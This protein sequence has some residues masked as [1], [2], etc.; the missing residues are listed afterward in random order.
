MLEKLRYKGYLFLLQE[1][2][3]QSLIKE[4]GELKKIVES[5]NSAVDPKVAGLLAENEKLRYRLNILKRVR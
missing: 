2:E 1:N 5:T 4:I 3:I